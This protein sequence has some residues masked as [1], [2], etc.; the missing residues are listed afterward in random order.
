MQ[1]RVLLLAVMLHYS[2]SLSHSTNTTYHIMPSTDSTCHT[3]CC[4]TLQQFAV[5]NKHKNGTDFSTSYELIFYPGN[6]SLTSEL[7]LSNLDKVSFKT[8]SKTS[9]TT[10]V[11]DGPQNITFDSIT[12]VVIQSMIFVQCEISAISH[13][14]YQV[15][16][17]TFLSQPTI[18]MIM[19]SL[20]SVR[21]ATIKNSYFNMYTT[22]NENT[23]TLIDSTALYICNSSIVTTESCTFQTGQGRALAANQDSHI[24][25]MDSRIMNS[26]MYTHTHV[27]TDVHSAM[28]E[29][30]KCTATISN[31]TI[32][33]NSGDM[34]ILAKECK[35]FNI[36]NSELEYNHGRT[37]VLRI[38]NSQAYLHN[39]TIA[40]NTG[41]LSVIEFIKT[42]ANIIGMFT[43]SSN[44]ASF[45]TKNSR[46]DFRGSSL[47]EKNLQHNSYHCD[48]GTH[49]HQQA[50][51]TL[52]VIRSTVNFRGDVEFCDNNSTL[53][54][55]AV[56][57]SE[58]KFVMFVDSWIANN[59]AKV[60][61]GGI[62][63]YLSILK[64]HGNCTFVENSAG[65]S[66][67]AIH[68]VSTA[69]FLSSSPRA[70][71][72]ILIHLTFIN[73]VA[74]VGGGLYLETTAKLNCIVD[75]I[76][77]S[78][79]HFET[80][81]A[82]T[83]GGAIYINDK[84]YL[85][86][87]GNSTSGTNRYNGVP[88]TTERECFFQVIYNDVNP[89]Q[90]ETE[91]CFS[92]D[93]NTAHEKGSILYGGL[94]DRCRVSPQA[95]IH[96]CNK[97]GLNDRVSGLQYFLDKSDGNLSTNSEHI[98]SDAVRVELCDGSNKTITVHK[99]ESFQV[100]VVAL[101]QLRNA[102][103]A[104]I[105]SAL[106]ENDI[107]G[108]GQQ[109]QPAHGECTT[110][111]FN[112]TSPNDSANLTLY[113]DQGP[114][115]DRGNSRLTL[116]VNFKRCSCPIGYQR[117]KD[118]NTCE[119][120]LAPAL[121]PYV[122]AV[123][124]PFLERLT[125]C[126]INYMYI[127]NESQLKYITHPQCPYDY[128]LRPKRE[129]YFAL[130]EPNGSDG[131]CNFNRTG[132]L[133]GQCKDGY[134]LSVGS[135][136]CLKCPKHWPALTVLNIT[137]G[138][139]NGLILV[140]VLLIMNLTVAI[141]TINGIIFYSNMVFTN[142]SLL[143][144]LSH[145]KVFTAVVYL[146]NTKVG[147]ERCFVEGLDA[148]GSVWLSYLF[149]LYMICLV[150]AVIVITKYSSRCAVLL[151]KTN[152]VATL[153]TLVILT[154]TA[155]FRTVLETLSF[156]MIKYPEDKQETVWLPDPSIKYFRGKHVVLWLVAAAVTIVGLV[157][158]FLLFSWQWLQQTPNKR[159]FRWIR[160]TKLHLFIE[161]YQAPYRPKYRY[162]T[163]LLLL[164]RII[165]NI[166]ETIN[167]P[168]KANYNLIVTGV[169]VTFVIMLKAYIGDSIYKKA[170]LDYL[171]CTCY[172]NL[173]LLTLFI[174][175]YVHDDKRSCIVICISVSITLIL[176][177]CVMLYHIHS[178]LVRSDKYNRLCSN[179]VQI[180]KRH[181]YGNSSD[182]SRP[183]TSN[184]PLVK[185]TTT[186]VA[187]SDMTEDTEADKQ[188]TQQTDNN[189]VSLETNS[190]REPLLC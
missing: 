118:T 60:S 28:I 144:H 47:F 164:V 33:G 152:P 125:D 124:P 49:V 111:T 10:I 135:S 98:A 9:E 146:L 121:E 101:D 113:A 91:K 79:I 173:L 130:N 108:K 76:S 86:T 120:N 90:L 155:L 136:H 162:W 36:T 52:T 16:G 12:Q 175:F 145:S 131:Q 69:L 37:C 8:S 34:I 26:T 167:I 56:Y 75:N 174:L 142:R 177:A 117:S 128:C 188:L 126:W 105:R 58:S 150:I 31:S 172:F 151:G 99:G 81:T 143:F 102:V 24:N 127:K 156:T 38:M 23:T 70:N 94:L 32:A 159:M 163:G 14:D 123:E 44:N 18:D 139:L 153:A 78:K 72:R 180:L 186:E 190:L 77:Q 61:G 141:G 65:Q 59:N 48:S 116:T 161:A 184:K 4:A 62:Y 109:L 148:Y 74:K 133:C 13:K 30:S 51:G 147:I 115:K 170:A 57:I 89:T 21:N 122:R 80:N 83:Y 103:N 55:G 27:H 87:C 25:I 35:P 140:A 54:G 149:P 97:S 132:L 189:K 93:N 40:N 178:T 134:S 100:S 11:C 176:F 96:T 84:T 39:M 43:Y 71:K 171:E 46:V 68:A 187:L 5:A 19:L 85:G 53:S 7:S 104:T 22:S 114:C 3:Q 64:C 129:D 20:N 106:L 29:L 95:G 166:D 92:F 182:P 157:Y 50:T 41:K 179:V 185:C 158:T 1:H 88:D 63:V 2:S 168:G 42:G 110:M 73:N 183:L 160:N 165:Q 107:L 67:G 15:H 6:H 138:L 169:L 137:M 112:I 17:C 82:E 45:I 181:S 66:G 154:Y 119:C